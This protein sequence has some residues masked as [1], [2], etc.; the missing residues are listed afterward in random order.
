MSPGLVD[1][2]GC[3]PPAQGLY[4][5]TK[6]SSSK[7]AAPRTEANNGRNENRV[8]EKKK[9]NRAAM[10]AEDDGMQ[11]FVGTTVTAVGGENVRLRAVK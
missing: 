6:R 9:K 7:T 3:V 1:F 10:V 11:S 8:G 5:G 4:K 2:V